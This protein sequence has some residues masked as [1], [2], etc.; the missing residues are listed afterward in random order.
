[1][2]LVTEFEPI[3]KDRPKIHQ[4]TRCTYFSFIGDD[5]RRYF[6]LETY[7]SADR[8]FPNKVSQSL[9]LN[10]EAACALMKVLRQEFPNL[11]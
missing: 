11:A 1:M 9:Q 8:E 2:A 10:E 6:V 4:P 3:S 5:N 7:G